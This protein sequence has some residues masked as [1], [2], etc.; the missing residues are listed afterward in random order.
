MRPDCEE[1][2]GHCNQVKEEGDAEMR[3]WRGLKY[4][5]TDYLVS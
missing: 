2:G 5:N 3:R 4:S 1:E